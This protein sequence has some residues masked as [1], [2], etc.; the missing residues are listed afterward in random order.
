MP[1]N[2]WE[3]L[4]D[5]SN[6][7]V[8]VFWMDFTLF[9]AELARDFTETRLTHAGGALIVPRA[10]VDLEYLSMDMFPDDCDGDT[11]HEIVGAA[12]GLEP[13]ITFEWHEDNAEPWTLPIEIMRFADR[14]YVT[15]PPDAVVNQ[16][17]EAF[18]AVQNPE[19]TEILDALLFDL[20]WDNGESYDVELFSS[21]P[22]TITCDLIGKETVRAA[23]HLYLDWDE[24]RSMG[25]WRHAAALLPRHLLEQQKLANAA[26]ALVAGDSERN[27]DH[28]IEAYVDLAYQAA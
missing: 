17:W 28:F 23:F 27:R 5:D 20:L 15:M 10:P 14:A 6:E 22:T 19:E 16:P 18:V 3:R 26:M 11:A 8:P 4:S 24:T 1:L 12:A 21:L 13:L 9:A 2:S 25:A 7:E